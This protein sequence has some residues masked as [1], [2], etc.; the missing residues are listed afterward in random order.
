[1]L[2]VADDSIAGVV[3]GV[4][5]DDGAPFPAAKTA[6]DA[7]ATVGIAAN[8]TVVFNVVTFIFVFVWLLDV[9]FVN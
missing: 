4:G 9:W 6:K 1:M 8:R 5:V 3:D 2:L 7:M